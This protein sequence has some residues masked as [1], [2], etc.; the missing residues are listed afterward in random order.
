M[1]MCRNNVGQVIEAALQW[2][3]PPA[4]AM[5]RAHPSSESYIVLSAGN[6]INALNKGK[7][8]AFPTQRKTTSSSEASNSTDT[9]VQ[10]LLADR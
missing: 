3:L 6:E 9:S 5:A 4:C 2:H 7:I 1:K 10:Y 8:D